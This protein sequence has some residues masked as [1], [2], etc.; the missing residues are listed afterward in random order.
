MSSGTKRRGMMVLAAGSFFLAATVLILIR[1]L[2]GPVAAPPT[3]DVTAMSPPLQRAMESA[4]D[5]VEQRPTD[6]EAWGHYGA[7]LDAHSLHEDALTCYQ[8]AADLDPENFR[9]P[10]YS[11]VVMD[12]LGRDLTDIEDHFARAREIRPDYAPFHFR[13]GEAL[14]R[15][16]RTELAIDCYRRAI[17]LEDDFAMA[18]RGLGQAL[19]Q[20]G[21][22]KQAQAPLER[23]RELTPE[24]SVVHGALARVYHLQGDEAASARAAALARETEPLRAV[25]DSVRYAVD[26][27]SLDPA[28]L[29]RRVNEAIDRRDFVRALRDLNV[30]EELFP[31]TPLY[32]LR[33]G[34]CL[35]NL[36]RNDDANKA[37]NRALELGDDSGRAH[38][39]L[40]KL[41]EAA[42]DWSQALAHHQQTVEQQ[43]R[44]AEYR[45]SLA[46]MLAMNGKFEQAL[47]QF[48]VCA[49]LAP[50][51]AEIHHNW[52][53]TLLRMSRIEEASAHF[54][55][56][57]ELAPNS[58]ATLF[59]LGSIQENQGKV[60][61]AVEL[62]R[63]AV[64]L[65][66][67]G[68]AA[69]RLRELGVAPAPS[70][71]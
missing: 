19:L 3:V 69:Q 64:P 10:Y 39:A 32:P 34:V 54:Q 59:N 16:G 62:Y 44:Q 57:L 49:S 27:L 63:R 4:R 61:D 30:L 38:R 17:Q 33:R 50:A 26:E 22:A 66:P 43:P 48:R 12:F 29:D 14:L 9:W 11:A 37:L 70:G 28:S 60:G 52:G 1:A 31:E 47:E 18:H 5:S 41:S 13:R 55:A 6:P 7:L 8:A 15:E 24:D 68:A 56:A 67:E 71:R 46:Q 21:D 51:T 20:T 42:E 53:T 65:D 40:A 25:R 35:A 45:S 58:P 36:S 23:A 2:D